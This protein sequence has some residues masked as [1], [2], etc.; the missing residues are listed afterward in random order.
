MWA[1]QTRMRSPTRTGAPDAKV[2]CSSEQN[3]TSAPS[4]VG[5]PWS[6]PSALRPQ[7]ATA[8]PVDTEITVAS[9]LSAWTKGRPSLAYAVSINAYDPAWISVAQPL[10]S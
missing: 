7:S 1:G 2:R 3:H 10:M 8:Q 6:M 5:L 4:T 9:T